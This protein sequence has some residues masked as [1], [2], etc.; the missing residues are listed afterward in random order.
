MLSASINSS[1]SE[2]EEEED[3]R[4]QTRAGNA[5][6]GF[7]LDF[8]DSD[9]D[10][11]SSSSR[12]SEDEQKVL[13]KETSGVMK[14][15][16][17]SNNS[18]SNSKD[19]TLEDSD[20][21]DDAH[22]DDEMSEFD[23]LVERSTRNGAII[24]SDFVDAIKQLIGGGGGSSTC[25][26]PTEIQCECWTT[27]LSPLTSDRDVIAISKTGSG[28]TLSFLVPLLC[29]LTASARAESSSKPPR[30]N[31]NNES[32]PT[33]GTAAFIYPRAIILAPTRVLAQQIFEVASILVKNTPS[34]SDVQVSVALSGSTYHQ[35]MA[36]LLLDDPDLII[37]T[38]GRLNLLCGHVTDDTQEAEMCIKL[39]EIRELVIDEAD[40]MLAL[41]FQNALVVC[42]TCECLKC[43]GLSIGTDKCYLGRENEF[44]PVTLS[45][46]FKTRAG[47]F[48][49]RGRGPGGD[50][51]C[52]ATCRGP[53]P[54][55]RS[56]L[57]T[58][59]GI[60]HR[61]LVKR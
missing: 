36:D 17:R 4:K 2:S 43:Q 23:N 42:P 58:F 33:T 6:A 60:A 12:S 46:H 28:K 1:E 3:N 24:Q 7:N 53:C 26:R 56:S 44:Q 20:G 39:D 34:L 15:D 27:M 57:Q 13:N 48:G 32:D 51:K 47:I 61:G 16:E 18:D 38:P 52:H 49:D 9:N 40:M 54:Q 37:A 22:D 8:S 30:N 29:S 21:Q 19:D 14:V 5:F 50:E 25:S 59:S 41:G 35:Q 45:I 31:N 11:S 10:D 55:G